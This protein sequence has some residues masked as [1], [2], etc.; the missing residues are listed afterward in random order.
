MVAVVYFVV[1]RMSGIRASF[2]DI[3]IGSLVVQEPLI[4]CC[5]VVWQ[6]EWSPSVVRWHA[7]ADSHSLSQQSDDRH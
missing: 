1:H 3:V 2:T 4:Q 7:A 5:I 6:N